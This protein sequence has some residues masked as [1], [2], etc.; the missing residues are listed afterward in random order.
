MNI[1]EI[2]RKEIEERAYD[3]FEFRKEY[4]IPGDALS[5]WLQAEKEIMSWY[6][7]NTH[8]CMFQKICG[9]NKEI[10]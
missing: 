2:L 7:P 10:K 9:I 5:D 8:I 6:N 4:N 1:N 3:M